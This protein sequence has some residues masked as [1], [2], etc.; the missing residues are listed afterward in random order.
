M[1][2]YD[3]PFSPYGQKVRIMLRE[4]GLAFTQAMPPGV[5]SGEGDDYARHNP[6][7]E[8][9]ALVVDDNATLY[10]ST[11]ILEY[12]EDAH[13]LPAMRPADPLQRARC[14]LIEEVC[15]THY[16]AINWGLGEIRFFGRAPDKAEALRASAGRETAQLQNWL[17]AQI[18]DSG[19][20]TGPDFGW[21]DLCAAPY[22]MMSGL[23]GFPPRSGSRL[24]AWLERVR[25]RPSVAETF[26]EAEAQVEPMAQV[27]AF[28]EAGLFKRQY[29]DHRLE[30]MIRAGGL[31]VVLDGIAKD[32]VRFTDLGKFAG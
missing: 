9:P 25:A 5:G 16:E 12:I 21:G 17:E 15:D 20:L 2:L 26:A 10:D 4:K 1:L 24:E 7:M 32:N 27:A 11:V 30:W 23:F 18:Q 13:P 29:R 28:L 19:W 31:D 8:V 14:R 22:V 6:R 3:H